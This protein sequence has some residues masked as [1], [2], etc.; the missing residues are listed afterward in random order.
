MTDSTEDI[1]DLRARYEALRASDQE[2]IQRLTRSI[3]SA[4]HEVEVAKGQS[5][6][7]RDYF[8]RRIDDM[9]G[10]LTTQHHSDQETLS[11][12]ARELDR[13]LAEMNNFREQLS[14]QAG[15]FITREVYDNAHE[16]LRAQIEIN[17]AGIETLRTTHVHDIGTVT[18]ELGS[19]RSRMAGAAAAML[20]AITILTTLVAI[21]NFSR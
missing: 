3:A 20:A 16:Y 6:S 4:K 10:N 12:T 21:L 14:H 1:A 18:G 5:V 11:L 15:T 7:I 13:R 17:R 2:A 19:V 9:Q 8:E